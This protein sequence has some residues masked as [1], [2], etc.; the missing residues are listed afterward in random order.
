MESSFVVTGLTDVFKVSSSEY[1]E[2]FVRLRNVPPSQEIMLYFSGAA[3]L[4]VDE[5]RIRCDENSVLLMSCAHS[6]SFGIRPRE[7]GECTAVIYSADRPVS[8]GIE[9]VP[10]P[11][12]NKLE[13]LLKEQLVA[14]SARRDTGAFECIA[15]LYKIFLELQK[16]AKSGG[17][18]EGRLKAG[19]EFIK[20]NY[21]SREVRVSDVAAVCNMSTSHFKAVFK[22]CYDVS[23]KKYIIQ[24]KLQRACD[25]LRDGVSVGEAAELCNFSDIHFFSRQFKEYMGITPSEYIRKN[26]VYSLK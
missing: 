1:D 2:L 24:L 17:S 3:E 18:S 21:L 11:Y 20:A 19:M 6:I 26:R 22:D 8:R 14:W 25:L 4:Y 13:A 16:E 23:P 7:E 5:G 12:K 9:C 10:V 15:I